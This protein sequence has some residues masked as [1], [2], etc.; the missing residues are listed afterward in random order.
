MPQLDFSTYL[1]QFLWLFLSFSLLY[2]LIQ[3]VFFPKMEKILAARTGLV[4]ENIK[5][6]EDAVSRMQFIKAEIAEKLKKTNEHA[7][8]ISATAEK[9]IKILLETK[10]VE[11]ENITAKVLKEESKKL[12]LL[13]KSEIEQHGSEIIAELKEGVLKLLLKDFSVEKRK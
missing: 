9:E 5:A 8:Q 11:S 1:G 3:F 13:R 10:A 7:H 6:A 2:L 4:E 12:A